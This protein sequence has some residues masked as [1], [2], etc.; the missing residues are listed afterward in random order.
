MA[1][2]TLPKPGKKIRDYRSGKQTEIGPCVA[3]CQHIDCAETRRM[4]ATPCALCLTPIGYETRFYIQGDHDRELVHAACLER[5]T[6][7]TSPR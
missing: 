7:A 2:G 5:Q 6:D 4:A 1:A 3:P